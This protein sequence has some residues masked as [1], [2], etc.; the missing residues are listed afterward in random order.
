MKKRLFAFSPS[1]VDPVESELRPTV[2]DAH[3]CQRLP[4]LVTDRHHEGVH[5]VPVAAED[6]LREDNGRAPVPRSVADVVLASGLRRRVDDELVSRRVV[7]G[8]R[9]EIVHVRA[10]ARLG[11]R[12]AA[13][14]P[15][16]DQVAQV[17][18]V[19]A[20]RPQM[21]DRAAEEP[22]LHARLDQQR[23]V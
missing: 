19:V 1:V 22:E 3:L 12:E 10:M 16:G 13:E 23:E 17:Q 9:L 11:H 6:Q 7:R 15:S 20:L 8:G 5:S 2:L 14:E 18:L 4:A 21:Q